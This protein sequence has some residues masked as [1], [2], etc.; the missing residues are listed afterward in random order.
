MAT[1]TGKTQDASAPILGATFWKKGVKI[2]GTVVR[3]FPTQNGPCYEIHLTKPLTLDGESQKS[4][5]IGN[6]KG[7]G[8]ALAAAGLESLES[9]DK[10]IIECTGKTPTGK[11]NPRTDFR[12]GVQRG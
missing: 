7:F 1:Y 10:V 6:M 11:G 9:G 3:Q 12:I 8:M 5:S 2:E 4:V